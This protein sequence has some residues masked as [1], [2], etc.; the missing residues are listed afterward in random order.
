VIAPNPV[1]ASPGSIPKITTFTPLS[2][3][4][5][6]AGS[7]IKIS[8]ARQN[9]LGGRKIEKAKPMLLAAARASC[10]IYIVWDKK[11]RLMYMAF[12]SV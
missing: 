2:F 6:T 1:L 3:S 8:G 7:A 4:H 12:L 11:R 9:L 5:N 10:N